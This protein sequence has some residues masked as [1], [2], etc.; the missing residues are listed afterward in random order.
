MNRPAGYGG[1]ASVGAWI[2]A[3]GN[4]ATQY[5]GVNLGGVKTVSG[6]V[7][8]GREDANNW[9]TK[10]KVAYKKNADAEL[11]VVQD[12][13]PEE[14]MVFFFLTVDVFNCTFYIYDVYD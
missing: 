13:N 3:A 11:V 4:D 7:L 12:A 6:I 1:S 9:V 8:Q 2:P 10:F 14:D 5:I